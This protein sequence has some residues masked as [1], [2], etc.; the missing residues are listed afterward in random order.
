MGYRVA[1][2]VSGGI[3]MIW[4]DPLQGHGWTWPQVYRLMAGLMMAA[5]VLSAFALP[6]L[7]MP[8]AS[9][10]P[11][12]RDLLGFLAVCAAVATGYLLTSGLFRVAHAGLGSWLAAHPGSRGWLDLG[13][14]L[15]GIGITVPLAA[16]A[17]RRAR[18]ETLLS[19]L[20]N[21]F[22]HPGA[23]ALLVLIVFYKLGDAFAGSLMTP[24]L[25]QGMAFSQAEVGVVNK[26]LG[27]WLSVLGALLGGGLMLRVGL[28]RALFLFGVLQML[29]NLGFW[30]LSVH[31][32]G[33]LPGVTLPAMDLVIVKLSQPTPVDGGLLM[34]IALENITG[35][36]GTAAFVAFLMS[37]TSQRFS[38]T[39]YALLSAFASVGRVWVGPLAGVLASTIGWPTFFV[40]STLFALPGLVMLWWMRRAVRALESAPPPSGAIE[41]TSGARQAG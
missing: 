14:L 27:I 28:W 34:V 3:A 24:F 33:A 11:M 20:S 30:W 26:T 29:S 40:I 7:P 23:V 8:A 16:W 13:L 17:A 41:G 12:R 9:P 18:F 35:G 22:A 4:T 31:G 37:L 15:L 5:A 1:M 38:A 2:V 6:R 10:T 39:Q 32:H 25:L 21:Y 19:G 36:M